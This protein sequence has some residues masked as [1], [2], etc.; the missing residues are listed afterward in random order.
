M[1]NDEENPVDGG[2]E[3]TWTWKKGIDSDD[4]GRG[5]V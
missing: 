5:R 4:E 2:T 3:R 1:M